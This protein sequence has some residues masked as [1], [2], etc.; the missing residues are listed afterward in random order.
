MV[1]ELKEPESEAM[2]PRGD[3]DMLMV[4][5]VR[6]GRLTGGHRSVIAHGHAFRGRQTRTYRSWAQMK[7]RCLDPHSTRYER[8]GG[9]GITICERWLVFDNFLAEMGE[10]P[11]GLSIERRD[12]NG[13]Y[14]PGN[15]YWATDREQNNNNS[16]T[17]FLEFRGQ[18]KALS[19]WAEE[20]GI[21]LK[22]LRSR[23]KA[24]RTVEDALT[25]ARPSETH[26]PNGHPRTSANVAYRTTGRGY[27][28][29]ACRECD[30]IAQ[31]DRRR[32]QANDRT[33][34]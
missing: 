31:R 18:R 9:R 32:R 8:Y 17:T 28:T 6:S 29:R 1:T 14:E 22:T 15:C 5:A 16:R 34:E 20:F 13:N 7:A 21:S 26:C 2:V 27:Q 10:C 3:V 19:Y 4:E 12:N 33:S 25:A 30:R 23:L 11:E 24:G